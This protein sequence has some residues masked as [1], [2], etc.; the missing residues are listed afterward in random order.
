M[1][2]KS[3]SGNKPIKIGITGGIGSGK[4]I[5]SK[6]FSILGIPVYNADDRAK[7]I[8]SNNAEVRAGLINLFGDKA[9]ANG[10]LNRAFIAQ[11]IFGNKRKV[12]LMNALVHPQVRIDFQNWLEKNSDSAYIMKEAALLYEKGTKKELYKMITVFCPEE[13]R[14]KRVLERD[15]H[16]KEED[17]KNIIKNQLDE[18]EK[19][20]RADHIIYND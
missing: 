7:W 15:T 10:N 12:E 16:R 6:I 11:E 2:L 9:F 14:I 8:L 18:N 19:L 13:I 3:Q 20:Q 5:I 1:P 17:V 4:S